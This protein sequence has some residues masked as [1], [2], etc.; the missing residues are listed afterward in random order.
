MLRGADVPT[1]VEYGAAELGVV[2]KDVLLERPGANVYEVMD[3]GMARC[4]MV[5][6]GP[7]DAEPDWR[8]KRLR[9]ATKYVESARR[10]FARTGR[11]VEIIRLRGALELAPLCGLADV[12]VDLVDTG[13]TLK[14]NGLRELEVITPISARLIAGKAA[15][16]TR[17]PELHALMELIADAQ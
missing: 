3:L 1:Y 12:I 16:K 14:A 4:R 17:H 5:V 6:A 7:A 8:G 13:E 10:H 2:G 9:V 15:A 11:Q